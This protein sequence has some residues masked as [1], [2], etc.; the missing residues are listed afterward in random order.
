MSLRGGAGSTAAQTAEG[1]GSFP[2]GYSIE[3]RPGDGLRGWE[4]PHL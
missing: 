1:R 3:V 4:G 2:G